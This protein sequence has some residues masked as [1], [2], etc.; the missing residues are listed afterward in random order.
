MEIYHEKN[1]LVWNHKIHIVFIHNFTFVW[2]KPSFG[3]LF[4]IDG[5]L[6]RGQN[7]L[8]CA[9]DMFD[10]IKNDEGEPRIPM[11]FLTNSSSLPDTKLT[12]IKKWFD[13]KVIKK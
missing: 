8:Q 13:I 11:A 1:I 4:D 5:V 3:L 9:K 12:M 10:K 6:A 2:F 7:A